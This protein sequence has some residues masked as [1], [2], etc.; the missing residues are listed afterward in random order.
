M[1]I[2]VLE[3]WTSGCPDVSGIS[4]TISDQDRTTGTSE[5]LKQGQGWLDRRTR[6]ARSLKL[7]CEP[8]GMVGGPPGSSLSRQSC[9]FAIIRRDRASLSLV[10]SVVAG[11]TSGDFIERK[12]S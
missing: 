3:I 7:Q 4:D 1:D 5:W 8:Q 2:W 11:E 6:A 12:G 10:A 9:R